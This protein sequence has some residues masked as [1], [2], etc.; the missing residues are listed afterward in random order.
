MLGLALLAGFGHLVYPALLGARTRKLAD[1]DPPTPDT[2]PDLAVVIPA[3][4]ESG[5]IEEKIESVQGNGYPGRM[6]MIVVAE[7]ESTAT[8]A[9]TAGARVISATERLGKARALNL[10]LEAAIGDVVVFTDANNP[11]E[12]GALEALA[13][14]FSDPTVGA[15]AGE[16]R[17]EGSEAESHYWRFE[18]WLKRRESRTGTTI[19]LVGELGAV[20]RSLY[21]PLPGDVVIDD[22]WI[23]LDVIEEGHRVVYEPAALTKESAS[24]TAAQEWERRSR[25]IAGV[26][27]LLV[28]R[29]RLLA[30]RSS[31][32]AF[33]L[34]G[35]RLVRSSLGPLAHLMLLGIA[36]ARIRTSWLAGIFLLGHAAGGAA[37]ILSTRG[38]R[39]PR[40]LSALAQVLFLQLVALGGLARYVRG[41]SLSAWPKV[42]REVKGDEPDRRPTVRDES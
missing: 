15:V 10:G 6:S 20:R 26:I 16:K 2:W 28:R 3:F 41:D 25:V 40:A 1:A 11:L 29:R 21:R 17:V 30:P 22:L 27:D 34:W 42:E 35:H 37:M 4:R 8:V 23:A 18:S 39:L 31:P 7:D 33:Q 24:S 36:V 38:R 12:P 32:A 14:W 13:R 5:V 9:K 19:G